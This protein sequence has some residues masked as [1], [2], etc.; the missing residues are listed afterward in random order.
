MGDDVTQLLTRIK[1]LLD[2]PNDAA[3]VEE[4]VADRPE[5]VAEIFELLD[6]E[7]RSR[8]IFALPPRTAAEV[9]SLL[10]EAERSE[11]VEDLD[12]EKLT[13]LVAELPPDDAAD[14]I[15]ELPED[16]GGEVLEHV[17]NEQAAKIEE[18]L[19]YDEESAGGIMTPELIALTG[20][21]TVGQSVRHVRAASPDEDLY[22]IYVT[23]ER[24]R[25]LGTV[26]LRLLVTNAKETRLADI[27]EPDPITVRA[28]EDQ[29]EVVRLFRKYDLAAVPV[30]DD[31][32][33]LV[34]RITTD[35]IMDVAEEEA[36]ED[37]YRMAGT[38]PAEMETASP[39]RAAAIRLSWLLPCMLI[40]TITATAI[41]LSEARF[42][43]AVYGAIVA[44]VPMVGA[45]SGNS[46][47]QISTV[48]V[49]GLATGDL[50][51]TRVSLALR[52]E[53]V[54][55]LI[56][57]PICGLSAALISRL[58]LPVLAAV[59]ALKNSESAGSVSVAVGLGMT[60]AILIAGGL[61]IVL[62]FMFRRTGVDPA[63]ASGPIITTVNDVI[64]VSI[65]LIIA[66]S[67]IG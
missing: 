25:L 48:I 40:M 15:G 39:V 28:R 8:I 9:I 53:G 59:G 41:A 24:R 11:V 33:R 16:R 37:L 20:D 66:I 21:T 61:G 1:T 36:A 45:M 56:M 58:G 2:S 65:Y 26:A 7:H 54:I 34:G 64:S 3:L 52:R 17:P 43:A 32:D 47:I 55:A 63:I 19:E 49:R 51:G 27:C 62:P 46:G 60:V 22:Q 31:S 13:E 29:E 12:D 14:V 57:A 10:D 67:I 5:D 42:E 38:D 30:L 35:D 4:L 44:F 18:L 6:D 23:D 50:A